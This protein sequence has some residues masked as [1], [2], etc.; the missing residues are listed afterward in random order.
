[1]NELIDLKKKALNLGLCDEY[2]T[3]WDSASNKSDLITMAL[4]AKGIDFMADSISNGW[5]VS[6]DFLK[7]KFPEY[8]NGTVVKN[9]NGYTSS[10]FVESKN[11]I[12]IKTTLVLLVSCN[13][14]AKVPKEV[15]T[16]LYICG[17]SNVN[18]ACDGYCQ[19][20]LY[21]DSSMAKIEGNGKWHIKKIKND[22]PHINH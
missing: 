10:M 7:K 15:M 17:H 6:T 3:K 14:D 19:V 16:N 22:K 18:V 21:G 9:P 2:K 5:G 20:Y 8:A 11:G 4:D 13:C 12:D 1:M